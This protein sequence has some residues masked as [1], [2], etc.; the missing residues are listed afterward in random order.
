MGRT[1]ITPRIIVQIKLMITL[2]II[3]ILHWIRLQYLRGDFSGLP[4]LL[5]HLLR[6]LTRY[7]LLLVVVIKDRA[8]VLS[9]GVGALSVFGGGVVHF[10]EKF[11]ERAVGELVGVVGY[12]QGFGIWGALAKVELA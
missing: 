7:L 10:V 4:P 1:L 11:E 8:A 5:L 9:A 2:G 3:P 12:L 6:D